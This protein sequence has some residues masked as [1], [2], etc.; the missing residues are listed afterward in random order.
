MVGLVTADWHL[1]D[2]IRDDYR[3]AFIARL[4][5]AAKDRKVD[6]V[7]ILGDLTEEKDRHSAWLVNSV[8]RHVALFAKICRVLIL[9]GNHDYID[10]DHPFYAFLSRIEGVT[11]VNAPTDLKNLPSAPQ[12]GL[13][14]VLFLPHTSD[15][16][17]DWKG[18]KFSQYDWIFAHNTFSGAQVGHGQTMKGIPLDVFP[19]DACVVSGDIH[20]PQKLGP[21]TYVGA[22][23]LV[24]FGDNY[25][26]RVL[27][28]DGTKPKPMWSMS[29][30]GPQKRLVQ[31]RSVAELNKHD[32]LAEGDILK[33]RI[34][35]ESSQH[36]QWPELQKAVRE[37]GVKHKMIVHAVQ[38]VILESRAKAATR[39]S[40]A[41]KTDTQLLQE[42]GKARG[43]D[44]ATVRTGLKLMGTA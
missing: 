6:W 29:C 42:Y 36:A 2:N 34:V 14:S 38:P 20:V 18:L 33:V 11:W 19:D 40:G 41:K 30:E 22:P 39:K 17:R 8:V 43:M 5:T 23:Y 44:D 27:L 37:W 1:S 3:H 25:N 35:L 13:G 31:V 21:V 15:Y 26:P 7:L 24:D 9:R 12:M 10:P 32:E 28:L 16:K 4:R